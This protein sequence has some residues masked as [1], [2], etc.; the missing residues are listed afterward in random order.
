MLA[1]QTRYLW[2]RLLRLLEDS[3]P[4][5]AYEL[6]CNSCH[7]CGGLVRSW[8]GGGGGGVHEVRMS[9]RGPWEEVPKLTWPVQWRRE[10]AGGTLAGW[11]LNL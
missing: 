8:S 7:C 3:L 4:H 10:E 6:F 9:E 1:Q 2:K 5:P 11:R